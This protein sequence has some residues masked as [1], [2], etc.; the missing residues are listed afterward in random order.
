MFCLPP[1]EAK[2]KQLEPPNAEFREF[3]ETVQSISENE[4]DKAERDPL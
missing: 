1:L 2:M 3:R 4:S